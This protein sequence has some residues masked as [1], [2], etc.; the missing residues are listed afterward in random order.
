MPD[1]HAIQLSRECGPLIGHSNLV[2]AVRWETAIGRSINIADY[3]EELGA[4]PPRSAVILS[5]YIQYSLAFG[6]KTPAAAI[7][8]GSEDAQCPFGLL[9]GLGSC[10][11]RGV[12][13]FS[14][15][16]AAIG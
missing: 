15:A 1:L 12:E 5:S 7:V 13:I 8:A 4:F 2:A 11:C 6:R 10:L 9:G 3:G 16:A 14:F